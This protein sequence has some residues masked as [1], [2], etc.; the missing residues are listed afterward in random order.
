MDL[1]ELAGCLARWCPSL[2]EIDFLVVHRPGVCH[3][4]ADAMSRLRKE[5][6]RAENQVENDISTFDVEGNDKDS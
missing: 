2:L 5:K 1:K 6:S 3:Q 4:A